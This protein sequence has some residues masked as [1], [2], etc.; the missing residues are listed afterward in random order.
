MEPSL[1]KQ[2]LRR[3]ENPASYSSSSS[4][5]FIPPANFGEKGLEIR[6][7]SL[8]IFIGIICAF[9]F[10]AWLINKCALARATTAAHH[11]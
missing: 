1:A 6:E 2:P 9:A 5:A 3:C 7:R 11:V 4:C 8:L 10:Y